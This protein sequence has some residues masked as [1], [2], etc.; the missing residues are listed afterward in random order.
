VADDLLLEPEASRHGAHYI[1]TFVFAGCA[2]YYVVS[3][4]DPSPLVPIWFE[5]GNP[6]VLTAENMYS[7]PPLREFIESYREAKKG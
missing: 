7:Y 1:Y 3:S 6:L 4:H 5:S 2:W